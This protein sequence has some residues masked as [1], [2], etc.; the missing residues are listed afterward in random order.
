[1]VPTIESGMPV[2]NTVSRVFRLAHANMTFVM[3]GVDISP[4]TG[5]S[6]CATPPT[7]TAAPPS[8]VVAASIFN[9]VST[10]TDRLESARAATTSE[11]PQS[12]R[13]P[14]VGQ[15]GV[16]EEIFPPMGPPSPL[17]SASITGAAS[18]PA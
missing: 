16:L 8:L 11:R 9:S 18:K 1:L 5:V 10:P 15:T 17:K 2:G 3:Q 14:L 6:T 12:W 7:M 4:G 13:P